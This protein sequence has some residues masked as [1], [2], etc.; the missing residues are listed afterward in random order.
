MGL[1]NK[2]LVDRIEELREKMTYVAKHNGLTSYE[3]VMLSQ[4]LDQLLNKYESCKKN[5][6]IDA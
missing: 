6:D 4:E 2:Q 1:Y 5:E 3:S